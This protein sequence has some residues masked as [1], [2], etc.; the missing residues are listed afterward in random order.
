LGR[1]ADGRP[2]EASVSELDFRSPVAALDM[3]PSPD[4]L[5]RFDDLEKQ[6]A[7]S[8][9]EIFGDPGLPRTVLIV[10][11][12][13]FDQ[14]ML[15]KISGAHH[16]EERML[17]LLLLIRMPRTRVI[18]VTSTPIPEAIIDYYLHLLPGVPGLHA[19]RRGSAAL[20]SHGPPRRSKSVQRRKTR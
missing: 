1:I 10:P 7:L 11:S 2:L 12:L 16:Y 5:A 20:I 18:Y 13:S 17:C 6:F 9:G 19:R 3:A 8:Y 4:E 14:E 15:A